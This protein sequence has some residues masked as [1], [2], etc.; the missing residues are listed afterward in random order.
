MN[1]SLDLESYRFKAIIFDCDGTLVDTASLH[2]EAF[3][4]ALALQGKSLD[5]SWYLSRTGLS[6]GK[7]L[8]AF[9]RSFACH[10]DVDMTIRDSEAAYT[11]SVENVCEFSDVADVARLYSKQIP[12]AVAS[13]GQRI[14]VT[15]TLTASGLIAVFDHVITIDDVEEGKPSPALFL[16]AASRLTTAPRDCLVF[17]D[18][19][20]GVEA[21]RRAEMQCIDVRRHRSVGSTRQ[22]G[23]NVPEPSIQLSDRTKR[24]ASDTRT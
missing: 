15:R 8:Q 3:K 20:E 12:T 22:D 7:L 24:N 13:G 18:T 10:V 9:E 16:E 23:A 19:D 17:E 21:A 6:A 2:F 1:Q 14:S 11:A 5:K 4:H